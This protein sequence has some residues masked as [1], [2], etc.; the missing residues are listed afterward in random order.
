MKVKAKK[1]FIYDGT[2]R[3]A[4]EIFDMPDSVAR[5]YEKRGWLQTAKK[6]STAPELPA[7]LPPIDGKKK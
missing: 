6:V 2:F 3:K 5:D 4:K 7:G 1:N